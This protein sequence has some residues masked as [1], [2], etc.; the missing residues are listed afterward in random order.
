MIERVQRIRPITI[1]HAL[2]DCNLLGA[3]L[4]EQRT[5]Q[6]WRTVLK[7]A[8]GLR[9]S[10]DEAKAFADVAGN[11]T[12]PT[13]RV[14]ELWAII[15]RRGGKSRMAAALAVYLACFGKHKLA[16]GEL[17]MVLVLAASQAQARTVFEYVKGFLDASPILRQEVLGN[18]AHELTLRSGIVI[19]VHSNSFRTVRGRT[20]IACIFDEVAFWRDE[21][22]ALPDLETYRAVLPS[23]ATTNGMLVAIST[24]YRKLGLL[25]QKHRDHFGQDGDE[26]LVVQGTT[27]QFNPTL[28]DQT[29]ATQRQADPT[30]AS[31]E[32]DAEFRNDI[33]SFLDDELIDAAVE[34]GRPLEL[35]PRSTGFYKAFVDA[36]GGTGNDSYTIAIAHKERNGDRE[37]FVIDLVRGTQGKFDP[38][39]VTKEYAALVKQYRCST[40]QGDF[41]G[42][43]WVAGA[44]RSTG[45]TYV[46]SELPKSQIYL[47]CVPLF[48]RG[49]VRLPDHAK[50]LRE[51]RLLERHVHRS[52]KDTVDHARGMHDDYANSVCGVLRGLSFHLGYDQSY[53]A[54]Q[55]GFQDEDTPAAKQ[56]EPEP[57]QANQF[58]WKSQVR[59]PPTSSADERLRRMYSSL[60][61]AT[62]WPQSTTPFW[63]RR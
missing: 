40:V 34:Y 6:T 1:D 49:L 3:A 55:P 41:Y 16:K 60:D 22:S 31:S 10:A 25:H 21:S 32:W 2:S 37:A 15:G 47:E 33:A 11:R 39:E 17:G 63:R 28:S 19:A 30:S 53:R 5:W 18:T 56:P 13:K 38:V 57:V 51:L 29:I 61:N 48:T 58:W 7:A 59:S 14:R 42:A 26:V 12:P 9:L 62:P 44:W 50:L 35:P 36:S 45:I 24:P 27:K 46:K 4:G 54:Y 8:F 52:G 20:L 43:E 23:L